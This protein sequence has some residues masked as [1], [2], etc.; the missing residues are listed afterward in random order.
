MTRGGDEQSGGFMDWT[1]WVMER[2]TVDQQ[3]EWYVGRSG[4][5]MDGTFGGAVG[6]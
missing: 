3:K 4:G 6:G 2:E 5:R 1:G